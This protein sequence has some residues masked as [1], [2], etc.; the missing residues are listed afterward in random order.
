MNNDYTDT[1]EDLEPE[2]EELVDFGSDQRCKFK[3]NR[4]MHELVTPTDDG[5]ALCRAA[6]MGD[7]AE[8]GRLLAA[9]AD[10]NAVDGFGDCALHCAVERYHNHIVAMLLKCPQINAIKKNAGGWAPVHLAALHGNIECLQM[11]I[12][13]ASLGV[14]INDVDG[15]LRSPLYLAAL[16]EQTECIEWIMNAGGKVITKWHF[17][18]RD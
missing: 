18:N 16:E 8:L 10:V 4:F 1:E 9:G 17:Y 6:R 15:D 14:S 12:S 3:W 7:E 11:L 2:L 5:N 13:D